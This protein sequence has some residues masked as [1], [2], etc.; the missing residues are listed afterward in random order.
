MISS[1]ASRG[2]DSAAA[3]VSMPTGPPPKRGGD[4]GEV[5]AVHLVEAD[6][7]DVEEA[8]RAVGDRP[9]HGGGALDEGEVAHALSSRP[10][11][12]GVP[13]ERLAISLAPSSLMPMPSTRAPRLTI[14]S[15]SSTS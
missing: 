7:I 10:A 11:M 6:R 4:G 2:S 14:C 15:S 3:M 5:L 8:Q 9:R 1:M 12:R 13:R